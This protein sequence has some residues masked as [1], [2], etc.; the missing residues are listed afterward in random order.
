VHPGAGY[1]R[2]VGR[3]PPLRSLRASDADRERIVAVLADAVADGRLTLEEHAERVTR[4][5]SARTLGDLS[6][7]TADLAE[8][9]AQPLRLD[10]SKP[11]LGIFGNDIRTG[12]WVV[13]HNYA[14][15][16]IFGEVNLDLTE[17]LLQRPHVILHVTA[18]FGSV[19]VLVPEGVNVEMSGTAVVGSK[20]NHVHAIGGEPLVE[21]RAF[22]VFGLVTARTPRRRRWRGPRFGV[23]RT[24][25]RALGG[26]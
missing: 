17:A 7:L 6:E 11:A 8:A 4:A 22:T 18:I 5:Y 21:I 14:A 9:A 16:A 26:N 2:D 24:R 25:G 23:G 12:R 10:A 15:T 19:H 13:P 1:R 20:V 3:Q